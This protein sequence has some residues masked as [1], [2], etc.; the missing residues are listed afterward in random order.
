M[1]RG[2]WG[3]REQLAVGNWQYFPTAL[4]NQINQFA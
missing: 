1:G 4:G 3:E 2:E